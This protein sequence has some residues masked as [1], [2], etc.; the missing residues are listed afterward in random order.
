MTFLDFPLQPF[1]QAGTALAS[2][3]STG[4]VIFLATL[5]FA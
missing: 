2:L 4:L 1:R 3:V 5:P